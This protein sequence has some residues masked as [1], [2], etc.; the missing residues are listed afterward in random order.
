[1]HKECTF[2]KTQK[3]FCHF[4][5]DDRRKQY[6][7]TC[8]E[9]YKIKRS[10]TMSTI[11]IEIKSC[12]KC[13]EE[14]TIKEFHKNKYKKDGYNSNCKVCRSNEHKNNKVK[15]KEYLEKN[16]QHIRERSKQY[17]QDNRDW[18]LPIYL[19][20]KRIR[21]KEDKNYK[22]QTNLRNYLNRFL[23]KGD[24]IKNKGFLD[25]LGC[26]LETLKTHISSQFK[27]GMTWENYGINTWHI[28]HIIP[29]HLIKSEEDIKII[30]HY[31]NL[32]P[33]WATDNLSK[34]KK[35]A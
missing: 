20:N 4:Y 19:E 6:N 3:D 22:L 14:K 15:R 23:K 28:D 9:C 27:P 35:Y 33:L 18:L 1:M 25:Y 21:Y 5:F 29:V 11:S 26:N 7:T 34:G 24:L 16:K 8:K 31:T 30:C 2:C 13:K 32:Q 10:K 17:Y 12:F